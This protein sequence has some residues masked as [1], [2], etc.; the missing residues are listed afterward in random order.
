MAHYYNA[1][2]RN[3]R[4]TAIVTEAGASA[5]IKLYT[6]TR[7][8]AGGAIT[9]QTLIADLVAN[10]TLGTVS[11]GVLTF[12]AITSDAS[13]NNSGTPT[14]A[15][16]FKSDGTTLVADFDL[17]GFPACGAGFSVGITGWTVTEG[18]AS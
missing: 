13:A 7:P 5:Q 15:R 14:W 10:A 1:T 4:L 17:A 16:I 18:N 2:I 9:T 11:A 12:G 8:A 6:G 3:A